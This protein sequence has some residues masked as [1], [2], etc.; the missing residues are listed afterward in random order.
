MAAVSSLHAVSGD[1]LASVIVTATAAGPAA[2]SLTSTQHYT[3][4]PL[5]HQHTVHTRCYSLLLLLRQCAAVD[6]IRSLLQSNQYQTPISWQ[7]LTPNHTQVRHA[8][9]YLAL[10]VRINNVTRLACVWIHLVTCLGA[11]VPLVCLWINFISHVW[12][13][14]S[15]WLPSGKILCHKF[16]AAVP[17]A[18]LWID[19]M[20]QVWGLQSPW[21][22][23][24]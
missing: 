16:G 8:L 13:L 17:L 2:A 14:Q 15:H 11:T 4:H 22:P 6:S 12:G 7:N 19:F 5:M 9:S 23:S 21:I 18:P 10:N 1:R 3:L 20:S 24:G